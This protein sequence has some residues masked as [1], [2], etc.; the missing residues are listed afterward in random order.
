MDREMKIKYEC[1]YGEGFVCVN[2][3]RYKQAS[4]EEIIDAIKMDLPPGL[5]YIGECRS[6]VKATGGVK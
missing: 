5:L 1:P 3:Y 6:C 4:T 2:G